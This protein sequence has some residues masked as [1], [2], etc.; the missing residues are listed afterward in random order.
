MYLANDS[1]SLVRGAKMHK[2]EDYLLDI[3]FQFKIFK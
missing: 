3:K 1:N 2:Q